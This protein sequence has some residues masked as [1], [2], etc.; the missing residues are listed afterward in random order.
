MKRD[1]T[2][3]TV[4][5]MAHVDLIMD[6]LSVGSPLHT[7]HS[8]VNVVYYVAGFIA[9][10]LTKSIKCSFCLN[11]LGNKH[12]DISVLIEED[13][14]VDCQVF[15]DNTNRGGLMKP[16]DIVRIACTGTW[17]FYQAIMDNPDGQK[18]FLACKNH[19]SVFYECLLLYLNSTDTCTDMLTFCC[20]Q[21]HSFNLILRK[22]AEKFFNVVAKNFVSETN[23]TT[24]SLNKRKPKAVKHKKD[25]SKIRKLQS[26]S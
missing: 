16:S 11:I 9:K 7:S 6:S 25:N 14:P 24:H 5:L 15:L 8:D 12:E 26:D 22:I 2:D 21:D 17:E 20:E 1:S 4:S 23:S 13:L 10:S 19:R 3:E 18:Y